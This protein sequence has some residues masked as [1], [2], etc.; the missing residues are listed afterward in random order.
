M[1]PRRT[2]LTAAAALI[3]VTWVFALLRPIL[4]GSPLVGQPAP[5][6]TLKIAMGEG[7]HGADRLRLSDLRGHVVVLDF[8]ASWCGPCRASVPVLS[9]V[10]RRYEGRGARVIGIHSEALS[11]RM[12]EFLEESWG[13]AYPSLADG[14]LEARLAFDVNAYPT[15]FVI[16][17]AG[18]IRFV[19]QGGAS[20]DVLRSE[21]ESL[22][23]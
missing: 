21:I 22:F 4:A 9:A 23:D 6:F 16:D 15:L 17:R 7:S 19:H 14:A 10:A 3:L 18:R 12:L 1:T 8:W 20:E 13:F 2:F 5:D 11:P